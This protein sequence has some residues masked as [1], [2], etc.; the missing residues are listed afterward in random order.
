MVPALKLDR[1]IG[2]YAYVAAGLGL[3]GGN[4]ERDLATV[5]SL[6]REYGTDAGIVD[7]WLANSAYRR[8]WLLRT[9]HAEVLS[10]VS[11]PIVAVWGLSY[12]PDTHSTRNSPAIALIEAIPGIP[13]QVYDPQVVLDRAAFPNVCQTVDPLAACRDAD[14]LVIA[15]PWPIF[16]AIDP[17]RVGQAMKGRAVIDPFNAFNPAGTALVHHRLGKAASREEP[18]S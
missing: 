10:R 18:G 2:P 8:D 17:Y 11:N 12:K 3:S 7:A 14:A 13:V 9:L 6:A 16:S 4:L 1:R 15:T 5:R